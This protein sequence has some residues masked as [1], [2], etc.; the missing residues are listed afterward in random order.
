MVL[1]NDTPTIL[2]TASAATILFAL[3]L[4]WFGEDLDGKDVLASVAAYAAVMV[5]FMG[6]SSSVHHVNDR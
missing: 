4:A 6:T 5:V 2:A 1:Y 3:G